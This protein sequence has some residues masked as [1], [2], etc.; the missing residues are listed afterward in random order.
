[1]NL[2]LKL[3]SSLTESIKGNSVARSL[4]LLA[5][6][7]VP[8]R[9][10]V[11]NSE[12]SFYTVLSLR[13]QGILLGRPPDLENGLIKTGGFVRFPL[14]DGSRHVLRMQILKPAVR[15]KRG[16]TV[17]LCA[18]P[19]EFSERSKRKSDRFNTTR[20][21]N[22]SL[23]LPQL[24]ARLRVVDVSRSGCK[25]LAAELQNWNEF[26]L[27]RPIH[28][29]RVD[30][31]SKAVLELGALIPRHISPPVVSFEWN[32]ADEESAHH[33]ERLIRSLHDAE[34]GRLKVPEHQTLVGRMA[35]QQAQ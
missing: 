1:M 25:V 21:K 14:P 20:F 12:A 24:D 32:V 13:P 6:K 10:E 4:S 15:R 7:R 35:Q 23:F 29:T 9:L 27:G 3:F 2:A 5:D 22:L 11:E 34:L 18:T 17:I 31:G 28:F 8:V 26:R 19:R 30:I 33:L 16:D